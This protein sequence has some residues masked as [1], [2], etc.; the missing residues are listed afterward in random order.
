M[1]SISLLTFPFPSKWVSFVLEQKWIY[2]LNFTKSSFQ[3]Y[4]K[5]FQAIHE[6]LVKFQK[7]L[8]GR[9]LN[10]IL[11]AQ[12]TE[13]IHAPDYHLHYRPTV[14]CADERQPTISGLVELDPPPMWSSGTH[15]VFRYMHCH[16]AVIWHFPSHPERSVPGIGWIKRL[17]YRS[18]GRKM[19]GWRSEKFS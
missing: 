10:T 4:H 5:V 17:N 2:V 9:A 15:Y 16:S 18:I 8:I 11:S 3:I 7:N 6:L 19:R 13:C 12:G 1:S 14:K